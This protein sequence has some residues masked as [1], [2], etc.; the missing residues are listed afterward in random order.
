MTLMLGDMVEIETSVHW[1]FTT[2]LL[3]SGWTDLDQIWQ[4]DVE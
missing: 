2:S 4:T 1:I 3:R